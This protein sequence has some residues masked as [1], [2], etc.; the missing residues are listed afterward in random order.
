MKKSL[1]ALAV[2]AASGASFAQTVTLSGLV[3]AAYQSVD[4]AGSGAAAAATATAAATA[5]QTAFNLAPTAANAAALGTA[6]AAAAAAAAAVVLPQ[7]YRG[8]TL[9]DVTLNVGVSEDLGGGM[10]IA[11]NV[12]LDSIGSS[13]TSNFGQAL[14][15]RNTSM[16]VSGGF[17]SFAFLNTRSGN[18][19]TKGMVAPSNLNDGMY[20]T[21]GVVARLPVDAVQYMTPTMSGFNGYAQWVEAG[22]DGSTTPTVGI[23]VLGGNYASGPLVGGVAYKMYNYPEPNTFIR[24]NRLE[25]FVTYDLGVAKL[26]FGYDGANVGTNPLPAVPTA[27]QIAADQLNNSSAYSLGVSVPMGAITLGANWA[28]RDVNT[29]SEFVVKYDLSKRTSFNASFGK[30]TLDADTTVGAANIGTNGQQYR[31]GVYHAF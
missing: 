11:V 18:L 17:G 21:S 15:R 16:V 25:A 20:D 7:A 4:T 2:L 10:K 30:Q 22:S 26:G 28:K 19:L 13:S 9:T 12:G 29:V 1:I 14:L 27:A 5:A 24:K 23:A 8:L 3:G 6:T 31:V